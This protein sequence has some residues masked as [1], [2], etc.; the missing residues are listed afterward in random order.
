LLDI[1]LDAF[2]IN[3]KMVKHINKCISCTQYTMG[4]VCPKCGEKTIIPRPP[5]FSLGDKYAELQRQVKK[6]ELV[7]KG[8]Y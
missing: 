8:L 6:E 1:G 5:K 2:L 3:L 4:E 7:K